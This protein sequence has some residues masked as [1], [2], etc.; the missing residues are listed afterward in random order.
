MELDQ[1]GIDLGK[2]IGAHLKRQHHR[3]GDDGQ[4]NRGHDDAPV[5]DAVQQPDIAVTHMIE[6]AV[7]PVV[8]AVQRAV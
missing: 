7:E 2:E 3:A 8:E 6:A 5:E 1:A 4:S